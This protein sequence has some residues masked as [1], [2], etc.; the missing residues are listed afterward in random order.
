M[1][2]RGFTLLELLIGTSMGAVITLAAVGFVSQQTRAIGATTELIEVS[3]SSRFGLDRLTAD[4]RMAGVGV[5]YT[6]AGTFGGL[7]TG[8]FQVG[9]AAFTS[10]NHT[11][12]NGRPADDLG[13][14]VALGGRATI[15][16]YDDAGIAE[17]CRGSGFRADERVVFASE[18]GLTA[19]SVRIDSITPTTCMG[20]E[21]VGGCDLVMFSADDT[22]TSGPSALTT[23]Y[24]GGTASGDLHW[25]TWFIDDSDG[26][27]RLRRAEGPCDA[28]GPGCG[29]VVADFVE[30]LQVRRWVW[31]EGAWSDVSTNVAATDSGG[32]LRV[33]VELV[34]RAEDTGGGLSERVT[35][36]L[37]A[38][39]CFPAC[40]GPTDGFVR[41]R[42]ATSVEIK[43]SGRGS[44]RRQR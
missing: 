16:R 9:T 37:E 22:Y 14:L 38:D 30:T 32:R 19:R 3:E 7:A 15:A 11:L 25:V 23:H 5:G 29:E 13:I 39:L 18:D 24:A 10:N 36:A 17:L 21:C 28:R 12:A 42:V 27:P 4:L 26:T 43:N 31:S 33:D 6:E 41:R 35:S 8:S 2:T 20:D 34:L 40:T 1:R 44:Y